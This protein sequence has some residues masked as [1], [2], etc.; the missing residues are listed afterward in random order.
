PAPAGVGSEHALDLRAADRV[1]QARHLAG[2]EQVLAAVNRDE[3]VATAGELAKP[4]LCR[5]RPTPR[6]PGCRA[7]TDPHGTP[8]TGSAARSRLCA[9]ATRG[10]AGTPPPPPATAAPGPAPGGSGPSAVPAARSATPRCPPPP[11]RQA[12]GQSCCVAR[13]PE[14]LPAQLSRRNTEQPVLRS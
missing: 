6:S 10:R 12:A 8:H 11:G 4:W 2:H 3:E 14:V 13:P 1:E 9:S 5:R 7:C